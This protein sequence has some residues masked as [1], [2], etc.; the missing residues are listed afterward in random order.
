MSGSAKLDSPVS[1]NVAIS[2][3]LVLP[4]SGDYAGL[5]ISTFGLSDAP[6]GVDPLN[7]NATM[8]R[9]GTNQIDLTAPYGNGNPNTIQPVN[10]VRRPVSPTRTITIQPFPIRPTL[11]QTIA[12]PNESFL[13]RQAI[14]ADRASS[15]IPAERRR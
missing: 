1:S 13:N 5:G 2:P 3:I 9:L 11:A 8:V 15:C 6:A 4:H 10:I 12:Q 14:P 7:G